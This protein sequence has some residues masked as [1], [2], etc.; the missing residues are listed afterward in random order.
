MKVVVDLISFTNSDVAVERMEA[1]QTGFKA[2]MDLL[3]KFAKNVEKKD[4]FVELT[5]MQNISLRFEKG[6]H[7]WET[8]EAEMDLTK[9]KALLE[10]GKVRLR[11]EENL[12]WYNYREGEAI[13]MEADGVNVEI[14]LM[15][16]WQGDEGYAEIDNLIK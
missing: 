7:V 2:R 1:T 15:I 16:F 8:C 5:R 14:E 11:K 6:G 12:D 9:L 4:F 13:V 3:K 10:K